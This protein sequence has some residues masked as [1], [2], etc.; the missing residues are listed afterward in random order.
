RDLRPIGLPAVGNFGESGAAVGVD[1]KQSELEAVRVRHWV[2]GANRHRA[3]T[4]NLLL[5]AMN[6]SKIAGM[7]CKKSRLVGLT[8]T[9]DRFSAAGGRTRGRPM[10]NFQIHARAVASSSLSIG[11]WFRSQVSLRAHETAIQQGER[12]FSYA[13]LNER[14]NRLAHCLIAY[15]LRSGDS[16]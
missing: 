16:I 10:G 8:R 15:G 13:E 14:V 11:G 3:A 7:G 5:G 2:D 1:R 6:C 9:S 12:G 4:A